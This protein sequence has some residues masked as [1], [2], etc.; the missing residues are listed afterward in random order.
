MAFPKVT[1][2]G[3]I[4]LD[5]YVNAHLDG[6]VTNIT[7]GCHGYSL[8][9]RCGLTDDCLTD[10]R[11]V[12]SCHVHW[13]QSEGIKV[14]LVLL[15]QPADGERLTVPRTT[16]QHVGEDRELVLEL[17]LFLLLRRYVSEPP[18]FVWIL[19]RPL[20]LDNSRTVRPGV[21]RSQFKTLLKTCLFRLAFL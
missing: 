13:G 1:L 5:R 6:A 11:T 3:E 8:L 15:L 17:R 20:E 4:T 16:P 12:G 9:L 10:H 14:E 2:T 19:P 18:G 7:P 21:K